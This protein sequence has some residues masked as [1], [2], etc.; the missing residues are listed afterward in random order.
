MCSH[1]STDLFLDTQVCSMDAQ[2]TLL[3]KALPACY[4]SAIGRTG[5]PQPDREAWAEAPCSHHAP[6]SSASFF[7]SF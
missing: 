7:R 6:S 3:Y 5:Q 1:I 2:Q 4:V